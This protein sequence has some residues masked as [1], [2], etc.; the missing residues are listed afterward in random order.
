MDDLVEFSIRIA[1]PED[2]EAVL[3]LR[4]NVYD[5][6]DY[7]PGYYE[8]FLTSPNITPFVLCHQDR[9]VSKSYMYS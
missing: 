9:I 3:N 1:T 2:K 5:G 4:K 8:D 6:R 7:L